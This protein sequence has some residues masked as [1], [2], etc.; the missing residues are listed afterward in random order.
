MKVTME[1]VYYADQKDGLHAIIMDSRLSLY[2]QQREI[3]K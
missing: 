1:H 3:K 2:I